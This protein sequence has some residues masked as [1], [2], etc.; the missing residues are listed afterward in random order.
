MQGTDTHTMGDAYAVKAYGNT[1]MFMAT[2]HSVSAGQKCHVVI[3]YG[4]TYKLDSKKRIVDQGWVWG[5]NI[6]ASAPPVVLDSPLP[7]I[8]FH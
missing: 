4:A 8:P 5:N 7:S 1:L 2:S 3:P 6:K